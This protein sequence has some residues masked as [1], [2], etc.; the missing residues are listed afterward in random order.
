[1]EQVDM[2]ETVDAF[3]QPR[4]F[5]QMKKFV[6]NLN[7]T[8]I[9]YH[10]GGSIS[11]L[12]ECICCET[13]GQSCPMLIGGI[14]DRQAMSPSPLLPTISHLLTYS[15]NVGLYPQSVTPKPAPSLDSRPL[16]NT[17]LLALDS[18]Q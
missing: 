1:M 18:V 12:W 2:A 6:P 16:S 11:L 8:I 9:L 4:K 14:I 15:E 7:I 13:L 3:V 17:T 10:L 5:K